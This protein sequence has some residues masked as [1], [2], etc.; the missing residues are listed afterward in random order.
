MEEGHRIELGPIY[1]IYLQWQRREW[2]GENRKPLNEEDKT[3]KT[4]EWVTSDETCM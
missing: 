2:G 4:T 1:Q 3:Q